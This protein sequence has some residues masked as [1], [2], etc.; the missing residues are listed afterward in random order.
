[1]S[2]SALRMV[3]LTP[4]N[5]S[6]SPKASKCGTC[7]KKCVRCGTRA[8]SNAQMKCKSCDHAF[9]SKSGK[10]KQGRSFK[11]CS[12]CHQQARSNRQAACDGCGKRF[13]DKA[14]LKTPSKKRRKVGRPGAPK[15]RRKVG[16]P[17]ASKKR[18]KVAPKLDD[19]VLPNDPY[20]AKA[21]AQEQQAIMDSFTDLFAFL[22]IDL[23][24]HAGSK[25]DDL[26]SFDAVLDDFEE[27]EWVRQLMTEIG[28]DGWL[29]KT[30]SAATE[31]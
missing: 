25:D 14:G 6:A 21:V 24:P 7:I 30:V 31:V 5:A 17:G 10:S 16:R 22:G 11:E 8:S 18:R 28:D 19:Q 12:H 9:L 2:V 20:A 23:A 15:K 27:E 4:A 29:K 13:D 3:S 1:M 26:E